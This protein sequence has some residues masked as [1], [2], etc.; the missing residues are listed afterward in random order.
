MF[1]YV[2]VGQQSSPVAM[3]V[4]VCKMKVVY[5][6]RILDI[7]NKST[8]I[9]SITKLNNVWGRR[10]W[11]YHYG[12]HAWSHRLVRNTHH[13]ECRIMLYCHV[14][15]KPCHMFCFLFQHEYGTAIYWADKMV[16]LSGESQQ[17]IYTLAQ[18]FYFDG[19]YRRASNLLYL[20][21]YERVLI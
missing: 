20:H 9:V 10:D 19:Q 21:N 4:H 6:S 3:C 5:F 1:V 15:L 14:K 7:K 8:F 2:E 13:L 11:P 18:C 12:C 16:S 17:D